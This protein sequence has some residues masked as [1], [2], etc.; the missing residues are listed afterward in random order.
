MDWQNIKPLLEKF[1]D[2]SSTLEEENQLRRLLMHKQLPAVFSDD[3]AVFKFY[4]GQS[5]LVIDHEVDYK[6]ITSAPVSVN[7]GIIPLWAKRIMGAAAVLAA[8]L[9]ILNLAKPNADS[10]AFAMVN[11]EKV[12]DQQVAYNETLQALSVMSE[13]LNSADTDPFKHL[14]KLENIN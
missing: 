3:A 12:Y 5:A 11:N 7:Q 8:G 2:G 14:K 10:N 6:S 1:Y 13:T 9:L 4:S